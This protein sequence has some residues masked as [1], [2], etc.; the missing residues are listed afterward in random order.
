LADRRTLV[1]GKA[2]VIKN[3]TTYTLPGLV[4]GALLAG[5]AVERVHRAGDGSGTIPPGVTVHKM[6]ASEIACADWCRANP[7]FN[8]KDPLGRDK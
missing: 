3:L 2:K 1:L 7:S 4:L 8:P 5:V 6:T